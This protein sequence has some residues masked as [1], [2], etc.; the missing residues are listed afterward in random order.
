[1]SWTRFD[2]TATFIRIPVR[3]VGLQG[4]EWLGMALDTG[5]NRT[6]LSELAAIR[7]G[8]DLLSTPTVRIVTASGI[9]EARLIF[10]RQIF[11]LG[12]TVDEFPVLVM[13]LPAQL[14]ADGLLGLDFL[15][16]RNLFCNF[17]KGILL[18]LPFSRNL[19]HRFALS[20]QIF[21]AL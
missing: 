1:M 10:L 20:A 19:T 15:R 18:T 12:V 5:S 7:L 4:V 2:P 11:A 21:A 16:L 9:A 3:I 8:Y 17:E 6:V 14:R 13:P